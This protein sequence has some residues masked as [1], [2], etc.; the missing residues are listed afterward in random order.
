MPEK[1][2]LSPA[3]KWERLTFADDFIF[4]RVLEKNLDV[5]KEILEL[6]LDI[7]IDRV[8]LSS[9]QKDCKTDYLRKGVRF[10]VYVKDGSGRCFD[11]EI[12][13]S[14]LTDLAKRARYYQGVMDVDNL[15]AGENYKNLKDSYVIFLCI[16]D[17]FGLGLPVYTIR[18]RIDEASSEVI[19]DGRLSVFYNAK[20]YA[21]MKSQK[22]QAFFNYLS[23]QK[24]D[25]DLTDRLAELVDSLKISPTERKDY[26]TLSEMIQE[27]REEGFKEGRA[28]G[29]A[30]GIAQGLFQGEQKKAIETA[31]N[32]L[33]NKIDPS[34]VAKCTG[35]PLEQVLVLQKENCVTLC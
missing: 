32:F 19:D 6:L 5:T 11:I 31:K 4:C 2:K 17:P 14:H 16:G 9:A 27:N 1:H 10:D 15:M 30:E 24:S 18:N 12:Q 7:Q 3:E 34:L 23:R 28:E 29:K 21:K 8:E 20:L 25:S 33:K 26:M 13:T 35:L 22:L